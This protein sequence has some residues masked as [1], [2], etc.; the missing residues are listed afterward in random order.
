MNTT[1]SVVIGGLIIKTNYKTW[2]RIKQNLQDN[3]PEADLI[4]QRISPGPLRIV[5]GVVRETNQ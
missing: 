2:E 1:D 3:Y 5:N 4:Y